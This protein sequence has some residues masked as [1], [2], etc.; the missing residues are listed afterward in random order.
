MAKSLEVNAQ[1]IAEI[2]GVF[3]QI[4]RKDRA[5]VF[6]LV[7]AR[8]MKPRKKYGKR[9]TKSEKAPSTKAPSTKAPGKAK[10]KRAEELPPE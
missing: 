4:P 9:K 5:L 7:Q 1:L 8:T 6:E 10:R 2:E 3:L